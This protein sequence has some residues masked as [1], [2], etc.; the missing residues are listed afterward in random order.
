MLCLEIRDLSFALILGRL[1]LPG[2]AHCFG[3]FIPEKER[4][5]DMGFGMEGVEPP[6]HQPSRKASLTIPLGVTPVGDIILFSFIM[7]VDSSDA[8]MLLQQRYLMSDTSVKVVS[9]TSLA[10]SRPSRPGD[11][12]AAQL[13][14]TISVC[15]SQLESSKIGSEQGMISRG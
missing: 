14:R 6:Q 4:K 12:L 8:L 13:E 7:L 5:K 2:L 10:Q 1:Q 3:T 11:L 15:K 9:F